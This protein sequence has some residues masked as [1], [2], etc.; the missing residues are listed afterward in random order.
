MIEMLFLFKSIL[1]NTTLGEV[2]SSRL[3]PLGL[4]FID[5]NFTILMLPLF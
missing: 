1:G 2:F 3:I 4:Y 5:L